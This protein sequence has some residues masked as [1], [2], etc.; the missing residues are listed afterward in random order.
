M[1]LTFPSKSEDAHIK[2][3]NQGLNIL[4]DGVVKDLLGRALWLLIDE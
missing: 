3:L 2:S 1:S 4:G